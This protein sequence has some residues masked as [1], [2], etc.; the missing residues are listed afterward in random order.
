MAKIGV[1]IPFIT[2]GRGSIEYSN[3]LIRSIEDS[4]KQIVMTKKKE[5]V[6]NLDFGCDIWKLTFDDDL[7]IIKEL[8]SEYVKDSLFKWEQRIEVYSVNVSK[9]EEKIF[10]DVTYRI[11]NNNETQNLRIETTIG[12]I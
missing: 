1:A 7:L 11:K 8:A 3:T 6:M 10:I 5:R 12:G 2:D 4:I 9:I